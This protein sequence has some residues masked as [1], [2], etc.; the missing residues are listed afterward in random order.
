M[1]NDEILI[2]NKIS[3]KSGRG[4]NLADISFS[5]NRGENVVIFGP[6]E[7]GMHII[8]QLISGMEQGFT[9]EIYYKGR[10]IKSFDYVENHKYR[11]E[12]G[13]LQMNYGLISNMTVEENISL[14][15]KYHSKLSSKEIEE[16]VG[17]Y[18]KDM[19][20]EHC[21]KFRPVNLLKS[22][23]LKTAFIRSI[24][25]NPDLLLVENA[26]EGQCMLNVQTF[27]NALKKKSLDRGISAVIVT[28][29][30]RLFAEFSNKFIMLYDGGI[31]FQGSREELLSSDN[32][33]LQQYLN[34]SVTGPMKVL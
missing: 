11:K 12:I 22:E 1:H 31:V 2:L 18:I 6:E 3:F 13:Y 8:C 23:V 27:L 33:Y 34:S 19:E 30:P 7:S 29:Y 5:I 20:L 16:L 4:E 25:L 10:P 21:R 24:A 9:G 28:Y 14:P 15:L 26:L 32:T 17:R